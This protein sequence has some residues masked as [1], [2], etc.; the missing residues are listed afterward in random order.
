[1][2]TKAYYVITHRLSI[3]NYQSNLSVIKIPTRTYYILMYS[4]LNIPIPM[5]RFIYA[6]RTKTHVAAYGIR[7][8]CTI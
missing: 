6:D 8:L 3:K 4:Y 1:M 7:T 5:Y 2:Y